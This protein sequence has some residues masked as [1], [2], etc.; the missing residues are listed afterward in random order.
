MLLYVL[1]YETSDYPII[2]NIPFGCKVS[3]F[4]HFLNDLG[5]L[6]LHKNIA[7]EN[8]VQCPVTNLFLL[9]LNDTES[10]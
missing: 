3:G 1:L 6:Y 5:C 9:M 8:K 7:Y 2:P 10:F 4:I